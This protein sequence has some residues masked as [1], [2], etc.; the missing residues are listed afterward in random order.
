M[1]HLL[2]FSSFLV[3]VFFFF[4]GL[5][6]SPLDCSALAS[7]RI[8]T[9]FAG[10]GRLIWIY[11]TQTSK[12]SNRVVVPRWWC[13][14]GDKIWYI[15]SMTDCNGLSKLV[16]TPAN[17][18]NVTRTEQHPAIGVGVLYSGYCVWVYRLNLEPRDRERMI[19]TSA[20]LSDSS[21]ADDSTA[22]ESFIYQSYT[23]VLMIPNWEGD[24]Y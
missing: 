13:L 21:L 7:F 22:N 16:F 10:I 8:L 9:G 2:V 15:E 14:V 1:Y 4:S 11:T 24:I 23:P 19:K 17:R 5:F 12:R 20:F 18:H 6:P 3:S